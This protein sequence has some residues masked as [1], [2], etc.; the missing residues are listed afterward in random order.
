MAKS[1]IPDST[2][3][4]FKLVTL[5]AVLARENCEVSGLE[6]AVLQ[7]AVADQEGELPICGAGE[8]GAY[9]A[10]LDLEFLVGDKDRYVMPVTITDGHCAANEPKPDLIKIDIEGIEDKT[11]LGDSELSARKQAVFLCEWLGNPEGPKEAR[12]LLAKLGYV[13][14]DSD[15][16]KVVPSEDGHHYSG[17]N[18]CLCPEGRLLYG[19]GRSLQLDCQGFSLRLA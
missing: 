7:T 2:V 3:H 16:R 14:D 6:L 17:R 11:L 1:L 10:S 18:I 9:S 5:I 13:C 8:V 4:C 19:P 15:S 12:K